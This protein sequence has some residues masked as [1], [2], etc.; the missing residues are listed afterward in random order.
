MTLTIL[1]KPNFEYLSSTLKEN[2]VVLIILLIFLFT[3]CVLD[4]QIASQTC[5]WKY[6]VK[7]ILIT[8]VN[9]SRLIFRRGLRVSR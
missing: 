4:L 1:L 9:Y 2:Q 5:L 8:V 3:G 6:L 7:T